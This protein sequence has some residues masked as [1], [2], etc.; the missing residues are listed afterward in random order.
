MLFRCPSLP[1]QANLSS[2]NLFKSFSIQFQMVRHSCQLFFKYKLL[3][4]GSQ[5]QLTTWFDYSSAVYYV[6]N[7]KIPQSVFLFTNRADLELIT[8]RTVSERRRGS[9][10]SIKDDSSR[11]SLHSPV[12]TIDSGTQGPPTTQTRQQECL[13]PTT[14]ALWSP[15]TKL[16]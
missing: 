15:L 11:G 4:D 14:L 3:G 8:N 9:I 13:Q 6:K 16:C 2:L 12:N 1:Y 10:Y 5:V 7:G